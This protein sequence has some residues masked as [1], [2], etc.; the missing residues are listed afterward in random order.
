KMSQQVG[1]HSLLQAA[2]SPVTGHRFIP[3]SPLTQRC[4][5]SGSYMATTFKKVCT[6]GDAL[7][8]NMTFL[9]RVRNHENC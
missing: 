6:P 9:F 2:N 1:L 5:A 7:D 4:T 3:F 8:L